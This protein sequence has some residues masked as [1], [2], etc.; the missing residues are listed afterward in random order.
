MVCTEYNFQIHVSVQVPVM[1]Y[2]ILH[3][4]Q[5]VAHSANFANFILLHF[6]ARYP[7]SLVAI[8]AARVRRPTVRMSYWSPRCITRHRPPAPGL[9]TSVTCVAAV[10]K[11]AP[12]TW[13]T[14]GHTW[15]SSGT[16]VLSV[17]KDL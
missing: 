15:A 7:W 1:G 4:H 11:R 14:S 2:D 17:T 5:P 9:V 10:L 13:I 12:D 8:A 3:Y 6:T 16:T